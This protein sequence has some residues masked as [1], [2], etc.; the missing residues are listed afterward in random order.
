MSSESQILLEGLSRLA[1]DPASWDTLVDLLPAET[2]ADETAIAH[3]ER[4]ALAARRA[5]EGPDGEVEPGVGWIVLSATGRVLA[6]NAPGRAAFADFGTVRAGR[7]LEWRRE[8]NAVMT[9]AAL[10]KARSSVEPVVLRLESSLEESPR[11]AFASPLSRFPGLTRGLGAEVQAGAACL[12]FPSAEEESSLWR[13]LR[14]S[15]GLT[16][17]EARLA[18][19]LRDG[20][21]LQTAAAELG[22]S[23]HTVRNHLR[24]VFAK[25]GVQRQSDL[26][27]ALAD[28]ASLNQAAERAV[29]DPLADAPPIRQMRLPDG[30]ALAYREY[31]DP[32]GGVMVSM[33]EAQGSSL[34]PPGTDAAARALGLRIIAPDRPGF[35]LSDPAPR[36][37]FEGVA[38][39]VVALL[40][41]LGVQRAAV[42]GMASGALHALHLAAALGPRTRHV[43]LVCPRAPRPAA[44]SADR[45]FASLRRRLETNRQ[46]ALAVFSVLRARRSVA[47]TRNLMR[48]AAAGSP[49]DAAFLAAND[50]FPAFVSAYVGEAMA[51][52]A[53]GPADDLALFGSAAGAPPPEVSA[54]IEAW[55]GAEDRLAPAEAFR[56]YAGPGVTIRIEPGCGHFLGARRWSDL[57]ARMTEIARA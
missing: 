17:A 46:V 16:E 44:G 15:F 31:G 56:A 35:G 51:R 24:A 53:R 54:P 40:D 50:W 39:D 27:R 48:R 37:T 52:S 33:H 2:P 49:G 6:V 28:L 42:G 47:L 14:G 23:V 34:L 11:F 32:A 5:G 38:A 8:A 29:G 43:M 57:M 36:L 10:R 45:A 18:R 25:L 19:R 20:H 41:G 13:L 26:V 3:A 1:A 22:V 30:R 4:A 21:S 55:C 9:A 7:P 12:M